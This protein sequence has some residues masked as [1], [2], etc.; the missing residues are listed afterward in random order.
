MLLFADLHWLKENYVQRLSFEEGYKFQKL[1]FRLINSILQGEFENFPH[2]SSYRISKRILKLFKSLIWKTE[3][4][5]FLFR[6]SL[7]TFKNFRRQLKISNN[8]QRL[9]SLNFQDVTQ[10]LILS[11][12]KK[13]QFK[14]FR[15]KSLGL[16]RRM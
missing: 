15:N 3:T 1:D 10:I 9:K 4:Y 16:K 6:L 11:L 5:S 12:D 7:K 13:L 8:L 2:A 14:L